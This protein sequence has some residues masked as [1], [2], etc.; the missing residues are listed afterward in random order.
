MTAR[1]IDSLPAA[2]RFEIVRHLRH[3]WPLVVV[4]AL[5]TLIFGVASIWEV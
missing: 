3:A 2:P 4:A 1:A 5:S